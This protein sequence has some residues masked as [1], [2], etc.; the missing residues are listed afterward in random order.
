MNVEHVAAGYYLDL[1]RSNEPFAQA[2]YGDGEWA[3][4]LGDGGVNCD[5]TEYA[6]ALASALR[7]TL[8][9]PRGQ[10]CG[11]NPG[12]KLQERVD[13]WVAEHA[14]K[15]R[16]LYKE[17]VSG[18]NVNGRFAPFLAVFRARS[19][20]V[21][22]GPHLAALPVEAFG[23]YKHVPVHP[24]EAWRGVARVER[25]VRAFCHERYRPLVLFAAGMG[26][27]LA[28][29]RLWP[30]VRGWGATLLDIGATLDPYVGV[31]SRNAYRRP[32]FQA[33]TLPLNLARKG[34]GDG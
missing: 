6:P 18:E 4:L 31:W 22:G 7:G 16:W 24:T 19:L 15:V 20:L 8:L 5:G 12:K 3:C 28:I 23:H 1:L 34:G 27:N 13:A 9:H 14:P 33:E 11:T 25:L 2:N 17:T 21:V 29:Q 26:S 10:W 32:E 30:E